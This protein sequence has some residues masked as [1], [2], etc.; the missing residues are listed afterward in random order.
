MA[1]IENVAEILYVKVDAEAGLEVA[2][3]HHRD[4]GIHDS[5]TSE[6]TTN[7]LIHSFRINSCLL[8]QGESLSTGCDVDCHDGLV[9]ELR[10]VARTNT[11]HVRDITSH[12]VED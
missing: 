4:L 10:D 11:S 7:C 9:G 5:G 6:S 1:G 12:N 8:R 3:K 2:G